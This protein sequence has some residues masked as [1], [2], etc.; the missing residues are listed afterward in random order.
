MKEFKCCNCGKMT[1]E[2][3]LSHHKIKQDDGEFCKFCTDCKDVFHHAIANITDPTGTI[4]PAGIEL[5]LGR[6]DPFFR[7]Q[8]KYQKG[9]VPRWQVVASDA[10][11]GL[12]VFVNKTDKYITQ[13][14]DE[15]PVINVKL[16][17][18]QKKERVAFAVPYI[19]KEK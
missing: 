9:C 19:K 1:D 3:P 8:L 11:G 12:V 18:I 14:T 7:I 17:I 16:K 2:E 6:K 13:E 4:F 5:G 10:R 15:N